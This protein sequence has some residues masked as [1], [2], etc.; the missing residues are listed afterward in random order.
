MKQIR[1]KLTDAKA[2]STLC[3]VLL[4]GG[5]ALAAVSPLAL[6]A[7]ASAAK[8][9]EPLY[10]VSLS[11]FDRL[12]L[13]ES[14]E[15]G[16]PPYGCKG[17]ET[18]NFHFGAAAMVNPATARV[19]LIKEGRFQFFEWKAP[20]GGLTGS[21]VEES[22]GH[23]ELDPTLPYLPDPSV[24]VFKPTHAEAQCVFTNQHEPFTLFPQPGDGGRFTLSHGGLIRECP[25]IFYPNP[26]L[27]DN[28]VLTT[29]RVNSVLGLH[30]GKR[31]SEIS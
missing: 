2:I 5:S 27:F 23:W 31:L 29:L 21:V 17:Q 13:S 24:C 28:S 11:L 30:K 18:I 9:K 19:S 1:S 7:P 12:E 4:V 15:G 22:A 10:A 14:Q 16:T 25:P 26:D 20:I 8:P 3:L 6:A